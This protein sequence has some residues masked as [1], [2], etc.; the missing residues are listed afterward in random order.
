MLLAFY[1]L[2]QV[3]SI[4]MHVI[5]HCGIFSKTYLCLASFHS[6]KLSENTFL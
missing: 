6:N 3:C 1:M 5:Y 4:E 2:K